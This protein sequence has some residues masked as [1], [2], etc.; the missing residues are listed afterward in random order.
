M[1]DATDLRMLARAN[2][3]DKEREAASYA[4]LLA[5]IWEASDNGMKQVDIVREVGLTRERVRQVCDDKYRNKHDPARKPAHS[6]ASLAANSPISP[7]NSDCLP[8]HAGHQDSPSGGPAGMGS[9]ITGSE[10]ERTQTPA[11]HSAC[12][13]GFAPFGPCSLMMWSRRTCPVCRV[14]VQ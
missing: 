3:K 4:H 12:E 13:P 8:T 6:P 14:P 11:P 5:A 1:I 9:T 10:F 7:D 2:K